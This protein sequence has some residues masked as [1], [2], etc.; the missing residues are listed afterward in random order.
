MRTE[1]E[2]LVYIQLISS[3][4]DLFLFTDTYYH[5]TFHQALRNTATFYQTTTTPRIPNKSPVFLQAATLSTTTNIQTGKR[6]SLF[7]CGKLTLNNHTRYPKISHKAHQ[8]HHPATFLREA[9][10]GTTAE[11]YHKKSDM[12]LHTGI[13]LS[14]SPLRSYPTPQPQQQRPLKRTAFKNFLLCNQGVFAWFK[15]K[16]SRKNDAYFTRKK[17]EDQEEKEGSW[18]GGRRVTPIK[19]R[20]GDGGGFEAL[21]RE[22]EEMLERNEWWEMRGRSLRRERG[23]RDLRGES[24]R[25]EGDL[26]GMVEGDVV[27]GDVSLTEQCED[28]E[29]ES[30]SGQG[31]SPSPTIQISAEQAYDGDDEEDD[32]EIFYDALEESSGSDDDDVDDRRDSNS[33]LPGMLRTISHLTVPDSDPSAPAPPDLTPGS[34]SSTTSYQEMS[35][36]VMLE[37]AT[38]VKYTPVILTEQQISQLRSAM[39]EQAGIEGEEEWD[40]L[41]ERLEFGRERHLGREIGE[42]ERV[43]ARTI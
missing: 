5:K 31:E 6:L 40:S 41:D 13:P 27:Q 35:S 34:H 9:L 4:A 22:R 43:Y 11:S 25:S 24:E 14:Q 37:T 39:L 28:P 42:L 26:R 1:S 17:E 10:H 19:I 3:T 36:D 38:T 15:Q 12:P 29:N 30:R 8:Q 2:S 16:Q 7:F 18:V 21:R 23:M 20:K 32:N 33:S